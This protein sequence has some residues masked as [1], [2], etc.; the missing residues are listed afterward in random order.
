MRR[1]IGAELSAL[2]GL[3][4][5]MSSKLGRVV[6]GFLGCVFL[7]HPA[8]A[9]T[10]DPATSYYVPEAGAVAA[11]VTG[12]D[13]IRF[14]RACP[15]NDGGSSLPENARIKLILKDATDAAIVGLAA[16]NIYVKFNGGTN[17]QGFFG[18]GADSVIANSVYNTDPACPLVQFLYADAATDGA[19]VTYITFAGASPATPGVTSRDPSRKWGHFDSELPVFANGVQLL[20]RLV[21]AGTNG[22]YVLRIKNFDLKGGLANGNNQGEVVSQVDY[23]SLKANISTPPDQLSYWQVLDGGGAVNS[24]DLY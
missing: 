10:P 23:N 6:A 19:G 13:A 20:G 3:E 11:P 1:Q 5:R 12:A 21:E 16:A 14:F 9:Q 7:V 15:N 8:L 22:D 24:T 17:V 18:N 2:Q 4:D